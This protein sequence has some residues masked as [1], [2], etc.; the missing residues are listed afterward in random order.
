[1]DLETKTSQTKK[2]F[3]FDKINRNNLPSPYDD[4]KS[5]DLITWFINYFKIK[6]ANIAFPVKNY[7]NNKYIGNNLYFKRAIHN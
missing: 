7:V 5:Y 4:G 6:D 1:M 2:Y 3:Y